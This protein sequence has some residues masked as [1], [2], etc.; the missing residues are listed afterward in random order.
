M[1]MLTLILALSA[2]MWYVIERLKDEI[3]VNL[4]CCKWIT[5]A[6]AAVAG[7]ALAF[8]FNL[9]LIFACGLVEEVSLAG[10]ILTGFTLMSGSSAISEVITRIKGE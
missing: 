9:D 7:F 6:C 4:A 2:V 1:E 3:W 10:K 5:I 8:A